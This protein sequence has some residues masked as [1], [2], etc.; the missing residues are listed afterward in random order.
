MKP[1]GLLVAVVLLAVLGGAVWYS[2]KKQAEKEK[3]PAADASPKIVSIPDDQVADIRIQRPGGETVELKREGAAKY[4]LTQPKPL[5]ADIDAASS[6]ITT[7]ASISADKTIDEKATDLSAYGLVNPSLDVRITRKDGKAVDLL[8]GDDTPN[9]SGTYAKLAGDPHVYTIAS[10]VKSSLD[11]K[12]DDLRDKHLLSF[13]NDKLTR[14]ELTAKG[15]TVEF[16][17]NG[18]NE[19]QIVKPHPMRAD[20]GQVDTLIGKLK[21]AKM[22]AAKT[23]ATA[24]PEEIAGKFAAATPVATASITTASGTQSIEVR[25][26]ADN[27]YYAKSS[28][29]EGV[30]KTTTDVGEALNKNPE[31]FRNKKL[32]EFGFSD[33]SKVDIKTAFFTKAGDDW[34]SGTGKKMDNATVQTLID[35]LRDLAASKFAAAGGGQPVFEASVISNQGK[36]NEKV[37]ISRNQDQYFAQREGDPSIYQLDASAVDDLEKAARDLKEAPPAKKK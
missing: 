33:P 11:K 26:D 16:G 17:K 34:V 24:K 5:P 3:A 1:K 9:N 32:F 12:A 37:T 30:Y 6:L 25:K 8:V 36:R 35:K 20:S 15:D 19:W 28:A 4:V 2:N 23:D 22:D 31:D 7:V 14:V 18:Q 13:D 27:N 10:F 29:V 21:D